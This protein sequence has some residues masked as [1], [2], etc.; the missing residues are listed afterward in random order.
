MTPEP[1]PVAPELDH[2]SWKLHRGAPGWAIDMM[3]RDLLF[4]H[5]RVDSDHLQSLL[6]PGLEVDTHEG[7]AWVGLVPFTMDRVRL[8]A[9]PRV[10]GFS[11]FHECNVRT[12]VRCEGIPG[13][14]FFSLDA[15]NP[16]AVAMARMVWRLNYI[17][18]R[19]RVR[20]ESDLCTYQVNRWGGASS[21]I[22]WR[23]GDPLPPA[24]PGSIEHFLT[25]RYCLYSASKGRVW[26]GM[27]HHEPW[28]LCTADVPDFDDELVAAAGIDVDRPPLCH[29]ARPVHV[30]GWPIKRI[31]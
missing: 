19:F 3:W 14:W 18:A 17:F 24:A 22:T 21:R 1:T 4:M 13:V 15:A 20:S 5:W 26:R 6:P 7:D 28:T 31:R 10:P 11:R 8:R 23:V 30:R 9:L 16:V 12:Y 2:D 29:A 25:E 27:V